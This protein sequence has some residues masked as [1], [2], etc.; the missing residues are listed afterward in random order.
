[1]K[2]STK[3][4]L[5]AGALLV[6]AATFASAGMP[7]G[8]GVLNL[9][10][11]IPGVAVDVCARGEVTGGQFAK[12]APGFNFK[13]IETLPLP[14]GYYDANVV[15]AGDDCGNP[16]P[17][18]SASDLYLPADTN[19]SVVAHLTDDGEAFQLSVFV[20]D[21]SRLRNQ[22]EL[23]VRHTAAAPTVDA[24]YGRV[25]LRGSIPMI[26]F[27]EEDSARLNPGPWRV[28]VNLPRNWHPVLG[29]VGLFL[30]PRSSKIVYVVGAA[31]DG[32]LDVIMQNI[33]RRR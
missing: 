21:T 20:N 15:L 29:P 8:D 5:L 23:V 3:K 18:L 2:T 33:D 4:T 32:T 12:V 1:M 19:V 11:G 31:A 13:Q 27:G 7:M 9:V 25:F 17:G 6:T 22:S 26:E 30:A 24:R 28:S 10:H 14:A 16:I